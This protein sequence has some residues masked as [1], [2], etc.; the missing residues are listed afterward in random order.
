MYR[1]FAAFFRD[2]SGVSRVEHGLYLACAGVWFMIALEGLG[3]ISVR[4]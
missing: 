2:C 1:R 3:T 4:G